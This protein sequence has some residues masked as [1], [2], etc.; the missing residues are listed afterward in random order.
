MQVKVCPKCGWENKIVNASCS[1]CF[2]KLDDVVPTEAKEKPQVSTTPAQAPNPPQPSQLQAAPMNN[3]ASD[4]GGLAAGQTP[5]SYRNPDAVPGGPGQNGPSG[6]SSYGAP[7][8]ER[9]PVPPPPK[10]S[11][12]GGIITA[13]II[14]VVLGVG[15][16][17]GWQYYVK[18]RGPEAVVQ[19]MMDAGKNG[20][21]DGYKA[22]LNS[23]SI[24]QL[25][26]VIQMIP[27]GE[28]ALK[29]RIK[30]KSG[31]SIGNTEGRIVG[32]EYDETNNNNSALVKVQPTDSSK[33]P[34]GIKEVEIVCD[35]EDGEWKIDMVSTGQRMIKK[36]MQNGGGMKMPRGMPGK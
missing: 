7:F 9:R 22:C 23:R 20:D 32:V 35:K 8:Q 24:E 25:N 1:N 29:K 4:G 18:S 3:T 34:P 6:P 19:K 31:E 5:P 17:F 30:E 28:E 16:Y 12:A 11:G 36:I 33:L 10:K 2:A 26:M 15:G 27:G 13:I 14:L 21:Y